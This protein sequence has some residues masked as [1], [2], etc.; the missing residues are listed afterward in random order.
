MY[1]VMLD[2]QITTWGT[3]QVGHVFSSHTNL[4]RRCQ[5]KT[6]L[7]IL[8]NSLLLFE[9]VMVRGRCTRSHAENGQIFVFSSA[10]FSRHNVT[11]PL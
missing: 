10:I 8:L 7:G 11:F 6:T 3:L 5:N 2:T 9:K 1:G 4:Q